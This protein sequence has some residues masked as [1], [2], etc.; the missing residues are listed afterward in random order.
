MTKRKAQRTPS[1]TAEDEAGLW[2]SY[3]PAAMSHTTPPTSR[4]GMSWAS[5][6]AS[7]VPEAEVRSM[8]RSGGAMGV[9][10][11]PCPRA[12]PLA[13]RKGL[14][15]ALARPSLRREVCGGGGGRREGGAALSG[16][17]AACGGFVLEP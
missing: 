16:Y 9:A 4:R 3:S 7:K 1:S 2:G 13:S 15:A 6:D 17:L 5:A 14:L 10:S 11:S 8:R 12:P